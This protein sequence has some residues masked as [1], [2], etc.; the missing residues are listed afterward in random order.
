MRSKKSDSG[1]VVWEIEGHYTSRKSIKRILQ[2]KRYPSNRT[3]VTIS[4]R[5][6]NSSQA[7]A[8]IGLYGN[9]LDEVIEACK[10]AQKDMEEAELNE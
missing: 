1:H 5:A 10:A 8:S 2:F 9:Q 6:S 3:R 4:I 7:K